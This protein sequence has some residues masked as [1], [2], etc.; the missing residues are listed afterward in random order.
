MRERNRAGVAI[1][2]AV[3][4]AGLVTT[5]CTGEEAPEE[6]G[7]DRPTPTATAAAPVPLTVAVGKVTGTLPKPRRLRVAQSVAQSV[8]AWFE[9]AYL[10]GAYP[11]ANFAEAFPGF[12]KGAR[13]RARRDQPL[14][15]NTVLG[16]RTE[17]VTAIEKLVTVDLFSPQ[18]RPS[19]A[20]AWLRLVYETSGQESHTVRVTGRLLM[21]RMK[22]GRWQIFG[23]DVARN[24][25]PVK[26]AP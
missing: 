16:P 8:D 10:G 24:A 6:K 13:Q 18:Q 4:V 2:A 19:G 11:R 3:L 26:G 17:E 21:T 1:V 25:T 15:T 9:A 5:G 20:T 7:K 23:Y 22:N 12:S 14:T